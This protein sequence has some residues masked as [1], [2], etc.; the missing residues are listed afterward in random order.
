MNLHTAIEEKNI[1][2]VKQLI[3]ANKVKKTKEEF[4]EYMNAYNSF[5]ATP[6]LISLRQNKF[7]IT[8]LLLENGADPNKFYQAKD[9]TEYSAI[10]ASALISG[11]MSIAKILL[12]YG[13]FIPNIEFDEEDRE[14]EV[15]AQRIYALACEQK[16]KL[17]QA[18]KDKE[19]DRFA[20]AFLNFKTVADI[21]YSMSLDETNE[22]FKRHYQEKALDNYE[23]ATDCYTEIV[24][25][26]KSHSLQENHSDALVKLIKLQ[27][28]LKAKI[29]QDIKVADNNTSGITKFFIKLGHQVYSEC[30]SLVHKQKLEAP[31]KQPLLKNAN[32]SAKLK[33]L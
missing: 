15:Y 16:E 21:W 6:L 31:A 2:K 23:K 11:D 1:E 25:N 19:E 3:Y 14:I 12:V 4:Y 8:L 28:D 24:D 7:E 10:I 33:I 22:I 9:F 29:S 5:N 27:Q 18:L 30:Q 13:A 17:Q 20:S 32:D 26:E